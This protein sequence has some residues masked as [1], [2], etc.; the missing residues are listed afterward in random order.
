MTPCGGLLG[1]KTTTV[2]TL[3]TEV[4]IPVQRKQSGSRE[5]HCVTL[6]KLLHL[7]LPLGYKRVYSYLFSL[8]PRVMVT[9]WA[10]A[11]PYLQS[12]K[13]Q[14]AVLLAVYY[15]PPLLVLLRHR[16]SSTSIGPRAWHTGQLCKNG[17]HFTERGKTGLE[18]EIRS[19]PCLSFLL[20]L[21]PELSCRPTHWRGSTG[22]SPAFGPGGSQRTGSGSAVRLGE[23]GWEVQATIPQSV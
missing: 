1:R 20:A 9:R 6:R 18:E 16:P 11:Q 12:L 14:G 8:T 2:P 13:L 21:Q 4:R 3:N 22:T 5:T 10:S 15:Q 17:C 23:G 7:S 19:R